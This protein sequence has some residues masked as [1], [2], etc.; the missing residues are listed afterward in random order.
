MPKKNWVVSSGVGR[1]PKSIREYLHEYHM[2]MHIYVIISRLPWS[3]EARM[4]SWEP[5]G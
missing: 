3:S 4:L 5:G 1:N 2:N